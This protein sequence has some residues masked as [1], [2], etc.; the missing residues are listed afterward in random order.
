[1]V[2]FSSTLNIASATQA[3]RAYESVLAC[4]GIDA[5]TD[6]V[7]YRILMSLSLDHARPEWPDKLAHFAALHGIEPASSRMV[8]PRGL[9]ARSSPNLTSSELS[10]HQQKSAAAIVTQAA[11][12]ATALSIFPRSSSQ[13]TS[14]IVSPDTDY[15][16]NSTVTA[17][18]DQPFPSSKRVRIALYYTHVSIT[19]PF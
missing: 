14:L 18:S 7:Y 4:R 10:V 3:L 9:S 1:M 8:A 13:L 5:E 6:T 17:I 16:T 19:L 2:C 11:T 12:Q 15:A